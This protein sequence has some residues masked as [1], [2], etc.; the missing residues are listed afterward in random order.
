[1]KYFLLWIATPSKLLGQKGQQRDKTFIRTIYWIQPRT[2][3]HI[4]KTQ[5]QNPKAISSPVGENIH[6]A[7]THVPASTTSLWATSRQVSLLLT[8]LCS[9]E[10]PQHKT[11]QCWEWHLA[12]LGA[13]SWCSALYNSNI[14]CRYQVSLLF[15]SS[16]PCWPSK[17]YLFYTKQKSSSGKQIKKKKHYSSGPKSRATYL[18]KT[19]V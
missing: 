15:L 10:L 6:Q 19:P 3:H 7:Q 2:S 1:M 4:K 14:S 12:C 13:K 16:I 9:E 18:S 5:K 8:C 11:Q 17:Y